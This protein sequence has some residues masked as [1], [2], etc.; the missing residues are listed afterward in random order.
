MFQK[1]HHREA[2][3]ILSQAEEG[4]ARDRRPHYLG[5]IYSAHG[6]MIRRQ[7]R[8]SEALKFFTHG[9]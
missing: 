1:G 7:G 6:R 8:Y 2:T 9:H 3:R 5:N 4:A